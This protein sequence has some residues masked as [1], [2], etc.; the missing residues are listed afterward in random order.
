MGHV[1]VELKMMI[2]NRM[3]CMIEFKEV[4]ECPSSLLMLGFNIVDFNCL[5][6]YCLTGVA[7]EKTR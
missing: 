4:F 7:S 2:D 6:V 1:V 3:L 5:D